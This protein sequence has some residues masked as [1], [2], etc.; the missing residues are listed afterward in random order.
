M[1][2]G[3]SYHMVRSMYSGVAGM[4]THQTRM[5]V[6]GNN[7]ANVNTYGFKSSR[8][9]FRDVYYSTMRSASGG[10]Q[11]RGGLNPTQVGY[12]SSLASI[13]V[14]Q[15]QSV[16]AT[17]GNPL[18]IAITGDG[19]LQVQDTDGNI[20]Y[21]KAGMLDIDANGNLVDLNGNF[22]LGVNGSPVGK[23]PG[24]EKIQ[25]NIPSVNPAAG[26]KMEDI[27]GAKITISATNNTAMGN[28][29]FNFSPDDTMP[30]G[31]P[32]KAVVTASGITVKINP[33]ENFTSAGQLETLMNDAITAANDGKPH[34][35][36]NFKL[37][38]QPASKFP[39]GGLTGAQICGSN[40]GYDKGTLVTGNVSDPKLFGGF[41]V[42]NVGDG[43]TGAGIPTYTLTQ[44]A[45]TAGPPATEGDFTITAAIA[46]GVTYTGIITAEQLKAGAGS[47]QMK[48]P[49][50]AENDTITLNYPGY[51]AI[52]D[53][54]VDPT[55]APPGQL[56][57]DPHPVITT[58]A[59]PSLPSKDLGLA[60][61]AFK[62]IGGTEGGEQTMKD[63]SGVYIGA[64]GVVTANHSIL[65]NLEIGRIDLAVFI[66]P[67]GLMQNGN[68]YFTSTG[69][70][71]PGTPTQPGVGGAG[72]IKSSALESSNVDL[73]QEFSDMITTQRGFQASSRLI[74]VSDTMLEELINLKR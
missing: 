8:A 57:F 71:G 41:T 52:K 53:A 60:N 33:K 63:L 65:G 44:A 54:A 7:I 32:V 28:V 68:T 46:N 9:T 5:D 58:A 6:I 38:I 40:F 67:A 16:M 30:L 59:T 42:N 20:F 19:F 26:T 73:S 10:D 36:G 24:Q 18:D 69:N 74:T 50:G 45:G 3:E 1:E 37:D 62:L 13:D 27:N 14:L 49:T 64:D 35:G 39:P 12:G 56:T 31:Q 29:S 66:N 11:N 25:F 47:I 43:F 34:P 72:A 2:K 22:V 4:K 55:I 23:M 48:N 17:T 15:T 61:K 21:T 70:S 51:Q